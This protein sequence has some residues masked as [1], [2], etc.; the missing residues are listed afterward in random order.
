MNSDQIKFYQDNGYLIVGKTIPSHR[1]ATLKFEAYR[2]GFN[3]N[4]IPILNLHKT[5]S[6][7]LDL[8]KD[9]D[10]LKMADELQGKRMIPIGSIF[11]HCQPQNHFN[12]GSNPH[13]DNYAAK[14]PYG[15]Y[16]VIGVALDDADASNGSLVVYPGTHKLGDLPCEP[17]KN[18]E[19]NESGKITKVFPI[20]NPVKIPV[21]FETKQLSY[22]TADIIFIHGHIINSA[23]INPSPDKWRRM[24]YMHY[25]KNGDYFFPGLN[26]KRE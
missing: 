3:D 10:I 5:S 2:I 23:P 6:W 15:S 8:M 9:K 4:F 17:H 1:L 11:F 25:I 21:G 7:F 26:A 14:A 12:A 19:K 22:K 18:F 13:Q 20:G 24:F 16:F